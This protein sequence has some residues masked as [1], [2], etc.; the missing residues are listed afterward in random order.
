MKLTATREEILSPVQHVIGVVERRQTM[1]VLSNVLLSARNNRLSVTGTDLEVE[2]VSSVA[3]KV[4]SAGDITVPG[5]KFLD[6]L[7]SL[8]GGVNVTLAVERDR[9]VIRAGRSRFTLSTLPGAEFPV[10]EDI[11]AQQV[12]TLPQAEFRKLIDKVHFSIAQQDVR[13]YLNGMLLESEG[14]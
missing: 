3:L 5:R 10:V 8:A 13:Y 1:P 2:L 6:I 14:G 7:R 12:L 11:N 9:L 4:Q